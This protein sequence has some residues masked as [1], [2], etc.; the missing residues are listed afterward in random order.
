MYASRLGQ[1]VPGAHELGVRVFCLDGS[2]G[3]CGQVHVETRGDACRDVIVAISEVGQHANAHVLQCNL[4][5][6]EP[7][8][9]KVSLLDRRL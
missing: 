5:K 6:L 4:P 3:F 7:R 2:F 8:A 9:G 1:V